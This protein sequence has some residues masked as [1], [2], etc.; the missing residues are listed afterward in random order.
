MRDIILATRTKRATKK[1]DKQQRGALRCV[2]ASREPLRHLNPCEGEIAHATFSDAPRTCVSR[3]RADK[4]DWAR[5]KVST[6][7][8]RAT[9]E[10]V[11]GVLEKSSKLLPS[12]VITKQTSKVDSPDLN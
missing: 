10:M 7:D 2:L 4:R 1:L 5:N 11:V 8:R 3:K 6:R 12:S 9:I